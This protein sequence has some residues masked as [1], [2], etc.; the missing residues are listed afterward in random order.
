[1]GF[2]YTS[3][4]APGCCVAFSLITQSNVLHQQRAWR[5]SF[6][7]FF[8][9]S[10]F[11]LCHFM[12]SGVA[13]HGGVLRCGVVV[14]TVRSSAVM[15]LLCAVPPQYTWHK[16]QFLQ[17]FFFFWL[18]NAVFFF[19]CPPLLISSK[20]QIKDVRRPHVFE[21]RVVT[22]SLRCDCVW[23]HFVSWST[24]FL[25]ECTGEVRRELERT[26]YFS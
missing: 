2:F 22:Q 8:F 20:C 26:F 21:N 14:Q 19:F 7:V 15:H 25:R 11:F 13:A 4:A 6:F 1:M 5:C 16:T 12:T 24:P 18:S 3:A 23:G 9:C 17:P 10:F